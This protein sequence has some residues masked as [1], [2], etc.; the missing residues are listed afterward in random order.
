MDAMERYADP[1]CVKCDGSGWLDWTGKDGYIYAKPCSCTLR[2]QAIEYIEESGLAN[3]D[4]L[5]FE[6]FEVTEPW[7][8]RIKNSALQYIQELDPVWFYIGGQPGAGKTHICTAICVALIKKGKRLRYEIW[9]QLAQRM[10][11]A[12]TDK[13]IFDEEMK[14]LQQVP[15][16][17]LDDFL[18]G[19]A[20]AADKQLAWEIINARYAASK[21]T[22]ISSEY[23]LA[24]IIELEEAVGSRIYQMSKGYCNNIQYDAVRNYRTRY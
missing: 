18:K 5:S 4:K 12:R 13:Y 8:D 23:H 16:L 20:T 7:Q 9:P 19:R 1:K 6:L 15:V 10:K 17:Y 24:Q 3:T 11:R 2:R 14:R 21:Q 22:I